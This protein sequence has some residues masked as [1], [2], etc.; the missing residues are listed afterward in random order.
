MTKAKII[1]LVLLLVVLGLAG[2]RLIDFSNELK[3][4]NLLEEEPLEEKTATSTLVMID[5][6]VGAPRSFELQLEANSTT[7]AFDLLQQTAGLAGLEVK[8]KSYEEM[9]VFIE[10]IGDKQ[11]GD[12]NKYWLYYINGEMPIVAADK[13]LVMP[14]D[15]IEFK[16]EE[17]T[18]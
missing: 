13:Q 12:D 8:S 18:F 14:G 3:I 1:S 17:S 7:T 10:A 2:W 9:G 16:F 11:N 4:A 15:K 6:G 5:N